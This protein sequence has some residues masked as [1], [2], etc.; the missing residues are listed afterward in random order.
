MSQIPRLHNMGQLSRPILNVYLERKGNKFFKVGVASM[1]GYRSKME[2]AHTVAM[3]LPS[4]S[5]GV[6]RG[7]G[8]K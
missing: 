4:V 6:D 5:F 2:D 7:S 1:Q 3:G 8:T